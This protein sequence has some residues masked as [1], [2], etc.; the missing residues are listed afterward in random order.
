MSPSAPRLTVYGRHS[1]AKRRCRRWMRSSPECHSLHQRWSFDRASLRVLI[2]VRLYTFRSGW[3]WR[4]AYTRKCR[5]R[6]YERRPERNSNPE[7]RRFC[8]LSAPMPIHGDPSV[9]RRLSNGDRQPCFFPGSR[10]HKP[11]PLTSKASI[12]AHY[13]TLLSKRSCYFLDLGAYFLT[14]FQKIQE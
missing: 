14:P 4:L 2:V 5:I 6:L 11:R 12:H 9:G 10:I 13:I 3:L 1:H 8:P 7:P